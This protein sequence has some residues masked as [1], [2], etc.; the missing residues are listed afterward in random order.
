MQAIAFKAGDTIISEGDQGNTAFFIVAGSVDV[1][2]GQGAEARTVGTLGTGEVF[3]EMCLIEPGPRSATITALTD[4]ECLAASYEEFIDAIETY[5]ER[6]VGFMK[7]L[8]RRL[9]QMNDLLQKS[10]H[11]GRGLRGLIHDC[12]KSLAPF[13]LNADVTA[14][15]WTMLW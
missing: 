13:D 9:R 5:P 11:D 15:S 12:R 7:T 10:G 8:V 4:V 14:L 2:I 6:A 3:G 1:R